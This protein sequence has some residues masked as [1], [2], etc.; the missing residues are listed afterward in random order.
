MTEQL[1]MSSHEGTYTKEFNALV[2]ATFP[3]IIELDITGFYPLGGGQPADYGEICWN[4]GKA[5]VIDVRK[6]IE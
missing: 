6:K 2:K 4:G 1:H 5:A 3:D